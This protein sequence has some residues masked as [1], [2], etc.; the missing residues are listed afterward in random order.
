VK[1]G[2]KVKVSRVEGKRQ[3]F[4]T[5]LGMSGVVESSHITLNGKLNY[6]RLNAVTS[7][8]VPFY[9]GELREV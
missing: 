9:D 5:Y 7:A 2:T 4:H 3:D 6:V 8:P 1:P